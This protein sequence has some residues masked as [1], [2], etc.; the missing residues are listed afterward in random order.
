[1]RRELDAKLRR[2]NSGGECI[3]LSR[4][5]IWEEEEEEEEEQVQMQGEFSSWSG[6]EERIFVSVRLRPLNEREIATNNVCDWECV[7]GSTIRFKQALPDRAMGPT[8]HTFGN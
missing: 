2:I 1:M 4:L 5:T 7:D 8:T 6:Q 3:L